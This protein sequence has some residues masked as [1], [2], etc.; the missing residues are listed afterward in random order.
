MSEN[1]G[2]LASSSVIEHN[3]MPISDLIENI[4]DIGMADI[5]VTA[6]SNR[7]TSVYCS[8]VVK[9]ELPGLAYCTLSAEVGKRGERMQKALLGTQGEIKSHAPIA[10]KS[11][12]IQT[13]ITYHLRIAA[14]KALR[15][16]TKLTTRDVINV[17]IAAMSEEKRF[18]Q[19]FET[20]FDVP[21]PFSKEAGIVP[22]LLSQRKSSRGIKRKRP[23]AHYHKVKR[24]IVNTQLDDDDDTMESDEENTGESVHSQLEQ[25]AE[26]GYIEHLS[27]NVA[28]KSKRQKIETVST[29]VA[30]VV[31]AP[32]AAIIAAA[33]A[34]VTNVVTA[35]P[36]VTNAVT[37]VVTNAVATPDP[38][39]EVSRS[40][41]AISDKCAISTD[42][43]QQLIGAIVKL[44]D[45]VT[46]LAKK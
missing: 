11:M 41:H 44:V 27:E 6:I 30:D 18:I 20:Q 37:N 38:M 26:I 35:P 29:V 16:N 1:P 3:A 24:T 5:Q 22:Q 33:P 7:M 21:K 10:L 19:K 23:V 31:I 2:S 15:E 40:L 8:V 17:K 42:S 36:V 34:I 14:N 9:S 43:N 28:S 4:S 12:S 32:P 45:L 25:L 39:L 13:G 46:S